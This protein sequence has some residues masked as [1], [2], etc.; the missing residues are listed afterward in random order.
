M[1][2]LTPDLDARLRANA[3]AQRAALAA[4]EREPDPPP[5]VKFFAPTGTATWLA[6][7]LD[8]DGDTLFEL[9]DLGFGCPELGRFTLAEIAALHLPFRLAIKRD[10]YFDSDTPLSRWADAARIAG[11]ISAAQPTIARAG[12]ARASNPLP[13]S[14]PDDG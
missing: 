8:A 4:G 7:E 3:H 14:D 9:A 1:I 2:L 12:S 6:T 5:I 13:P 10:L 11:S